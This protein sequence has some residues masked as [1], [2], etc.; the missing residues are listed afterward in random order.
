MQAPMVVQRRNKSDAWKDAGDAE[1]H[2][3]HMRKAI[4]AIMQDRERHNRNLPRL[5]KILEIQL[6]QSAESLGEYLDRTSL[7]SRLR[8][9]NELIQQ[10]EAKPRQTSMSS[11]ATVVSTDSS[12]SCDWKSASTIPAE[13]RRMSLQI[14]KLL[15]SRQKGL[16]KQALLP[17]SKRLEVSLFRQSQ[18]LEDY[19]NTDAL[20][21]KLL[22]LLNACLTQRSTTTKSS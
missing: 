4:T 22:S 15:E 14:F 8:K 2:R 1:L 12:S 13:R 6:F 7:R 20:R 3:R 17:M 21:K 10:L 5:V 16:P 11:S 18:S 9:A 19:T